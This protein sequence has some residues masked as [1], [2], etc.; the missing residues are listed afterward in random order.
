[1]R[2]LLNEGIAIV[3]DPDRQRSQLQQLRPEVSHPL[4]VDIKLLVR[5]T[6]AT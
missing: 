3:N 1:M 6:C 2:G 5:R 4:M